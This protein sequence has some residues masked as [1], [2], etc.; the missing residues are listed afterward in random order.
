MTKIKFFSLCLLGLLLGL[1]SCNKNDVAPIYIPLP[2]IETYHPELKE[3]DI[4]EIQ[5]SIPYIDETFIVNSIAEIPDDIIFGNDE[6]LDQDIDFSQYSLIIFYNLQFG[7]ILS[8]D[9]KWVYNSDLEQYQV[10]VSYEI[11]K[12]SAI[13]GEIESATY[14]RGAMLVDH[15]PDTLFVGQW[16]GVHWI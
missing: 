10:A 14:V 1:T 6:F 4:S 16:I 3:F 8:T 11:E 12:D 5:N 7:K 9:Y 2:V 15:I 13:N